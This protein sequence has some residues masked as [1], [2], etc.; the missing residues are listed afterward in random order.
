MQKKAGSKSKKGSK[1][2][3]AELTD[4]R[5]SL[6]NVIEELTETQEKLEGSEERYRILIETS[7]DAITFTD[8]IGNFIMVNKQAALLHGFD[9]VEEMLS[10][11]KDAFDLIAPEDGQRAID[12]VKRTLEAGSIRN[13][14]Y[15]L[16]CKD[17]SKVPAELSASVFL[18]SQGRPRGF[19]GVIRDISEHKNAE[20]QLQD[21][22]DKMEDCVNERTKELLK[23]NEDLKKTIKELRKTEEELRHSEERF[24]IV[25]EGALAGVYMVQN[26]RFVY[27][28]PALALM[29]GYD[30]KE[31]INKLGPLELTHP[32]DQALVAEQIRRRLSKEKKQVRY[33]F[34]GIRKDGKVIHCEVMGRRLE[35]KGVPTIIGLLLD[36]TTRQKAENEMRK[37]LMKYSLDEGSLYLVEEPSRILSFEAFKDLLRVG[38]QGYVFSRTPEEEFRTIIGGDYDFSWLSEKGERSLSPKLREIHLFV[39]NLPNRNAILIDRVDY[40]IFKNGFS[41]TLSF[42]QSLRDIAYLSNHIVILSVD[43][44]AVS[45]RELRLLEKEAKEIETLQKD[46]LP[47]DLIEAMRF[48]NKQNVIGVKPSYADLGR[49]L[50]ISKPTVQKRIKKLN[51]A[52]YINEAVNGRRKTVEISEKGRNLFFR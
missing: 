44:L 25:T 14:E 18:D 41:E 24:R 7:P 16:L 42:V 29:F 36:V 46:Q 35:Y 20:Q 12:N 22:Y 15:T 10:S 1:F 23:T 33:N 17:G 31:M 37:M 9:T 21:A 19:I 34:R 40:L 48:I 45:K 32:D 6:I 49:G 28:N 13:A 3:S 30:Q 43:P 47:D 26:Y 5:K 38:Y 8:L 2:K 4:A 27:V 51:S 11:G 39:E 50:A 52:G